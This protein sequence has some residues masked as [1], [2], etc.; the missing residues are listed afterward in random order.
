MRY[1][2]VENGM[3]ANATSFE[4]EKPDGWDAP[5]I[6]IQSDTVGLGWSYDGSVF[7]PPD[8]IP[9]PPPTPEQLRK[10]S[11]MADAD[12]IDLLQRAATATPTQI[13]SWLSANVTNLAQAR[14]VLGALIKVIA[15]KLA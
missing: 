10:T 9:D 15:V 3:V 4:G 5:N 8:P 12:Y 11:M 6:W 13:D 14:A 1:V 2:R 7:T